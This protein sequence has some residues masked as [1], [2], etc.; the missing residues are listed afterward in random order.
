MSEMCHFPYENI[1]E[2][3]GSFIAQFHFEEANIFVV[4][5]IKTVKSCKTK[6][7]KELVLQR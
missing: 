6:T 5:L 7:L 3:D 1:R 4:D 2:V